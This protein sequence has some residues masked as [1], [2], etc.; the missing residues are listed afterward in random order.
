MIL[1]LWPNIQGLS[2]WMVHVKCSIQI[3]YVQLVDSV[4]KPSIA[5]LIFFLLFSQ[6]LREACYMSSYNNSAPFRSIS[7]PSCIPCI[8]SEG[9][10]VSKEA[11]F[12]LGKMKN[13]TDITMVW[14]SVRTVTT[15]DEVSLFITVIFCVLKYTLIYNHSHFLLLSICMCNRV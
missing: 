12:V 11:K 8:L 6:L 4:F 5:L 10:I 15:C 13:K 2:W 7:F 3:N 1:V 14:S 9:D